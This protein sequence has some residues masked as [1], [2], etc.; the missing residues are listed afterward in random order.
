MHYPKN[1]HSSY[2][3]VYHGIVYHTVS[4]SY[5]WMLASKKILHWNLE[6]AN[7]KFVKFKLR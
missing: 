7:G 6:F 3:D 2:V 1:I 5:R 4:T